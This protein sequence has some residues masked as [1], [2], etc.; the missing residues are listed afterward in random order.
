M[1]PTV[2]EIVVGGFR[3]L[4]GALQFLEKSPTTTR[5]KPFSKPSAPWWWKPRQKK[6]QELPKLFNNTGE[7]SA[8]LEALLWILAQEEADS[9]DQKWKTK[10]LSI[11]ISTVL[12]SETLY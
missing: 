10:P 5:L 3:M 8:V 2:K 1:G 6:L 11:S 7:A 12:M 4:G 9:P